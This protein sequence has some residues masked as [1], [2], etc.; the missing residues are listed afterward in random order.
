MS[1]VI[2]QNLFAIFQYFI[3]NLWRINVIPVLKANLIISPFFEFTSLFWVESYGRLNLYNPLVFKLEYSNQKTRL[4]KCRPAYIQ[5]LILLRKKSV[6]FHELV[7]NVI[8]CRLII[9]N[10]HFGILANNC[11]NCVVLIFVNAVDNNAW[12]NFASIQNR[13]HLRDFTIVHHFV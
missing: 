7:N 13:K 8:G 1:I 10:T 4:V 3:I 12:F 6:A 2:C 9:S 11:W 5:I